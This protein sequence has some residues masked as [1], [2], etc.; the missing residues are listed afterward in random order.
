LARRSVALALPSI[1]I[2]QETNYLLNPAHPD[3]R[4]LASG[5]ME[6]FDFDQR[7]LG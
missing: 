7:L 3:F 4:R 5:P 2:P 1:I 6:D